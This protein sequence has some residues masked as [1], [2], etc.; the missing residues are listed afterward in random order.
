VARRL[1]FGTRALDFLPTAQSWDSGEFVAALGRVAPAT[2]VTVEYGGHAY[3][4]TS[5]E[6]G[7][8]GLIHAAD[9]ARTGDLPAVVSVVPAS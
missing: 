6:F 4:R 1:N 9:S 7:V 2:D 3:H 8:W 5:N